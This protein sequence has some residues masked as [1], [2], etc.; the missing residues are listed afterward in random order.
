MNKRRMSLLASLLVLLT[1]CSAPAGPEQGTEGVLVYYLL[2]EEEARGADRIG[3]RWESLA[4]PEG[5]DDLTEAR[6][7]VER[8]MAGPEDESMYSPLPEGV[9][10]LGLELRDRTAYVDFSG[11]IRD[12]SGVE[13]ALAD[14]CLTLSLTALDSVRAVTVTAQGRPLGQQPKQVFYERDVLLSDMGD[15]LQTVEVSLY[16]LNA[17]GALAAEKRMLSLYEGQTLAEALVAALLEGPESR[18]LLRAVPEGF[19]INYVR[20][21]SGVCYLSLPAS[22]LAL[23]PQDGQT[24]QMILWSLADSLYSIDSVEEI[25]LLADGEELKLF[26]SVPVE[27]VAVRPQG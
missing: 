23:L 18:E 14:Y 5:A 10:L 24:Q 25:R 22:S 11:E 7:V 17:D 4:L 15:V 20:V 21:D 1:A 13:L 27:S 6:A 9:E 8:L 26:G 12:L 2:P 19:A 3:A 16:F